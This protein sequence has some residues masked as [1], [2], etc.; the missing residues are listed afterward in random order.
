MKDV[1]G[2]F[3][4]DAHLTGE[5]AALKAAADAGNRAVMVGAL[6]VDGLGEAALELG[7][8]VGDVGHKVGKGAVDLAHHA[9]LV[10]VNAEVFA[11]GGLE[12]EG[13]VA[14]FGCLLYTSPSPRDGLLSRMPS[15]A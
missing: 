1:F 6:N 4:R 11:F 14:F 2:E 12:P 8:V 3:L 7:K 15:S 9:V 10:V 5:R 13:A